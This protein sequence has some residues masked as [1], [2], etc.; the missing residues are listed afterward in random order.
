MSLSHFAEL[1]VEE[2]ANVITHGAG[3]LLSVV[4]FAVLL[5][6]AIVHGDVWHVTSTVVYGSSLVILY[7][8]ST[9]YHSAITPHRKS[10]L[11]MLDHCCI[12]LLI[13]G[14]Y[15]PFL[16]VVLRDGI[17]PGMLA[18]VWAIAVFGIVFKL[19]FRQRFKGLGIFLYLA[20]GWLGLVVAPAMYAAMG[21]TPLLYIVAGGV[22]YTAGM[23]FFGW[24]SIK[25]HH[26]IFHV[27]VLLGSI[28]H[29]IAITTYI[30][31]H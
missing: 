28:L 30:V 12:Y 4:G 18:I 9:L 16:L 17:G 20:M 7:A 27:F 8:A 31:P 21:L 3:L 24:K 6:L 26:A 25:H 10:L 2:L 22:S 23:I 29:Y 1:S 13:A 14:S 19:I 11:Q 5:V 15:T